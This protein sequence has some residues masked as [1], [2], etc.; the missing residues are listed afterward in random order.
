MILDVMIKQKGQGSTIENGECTIFDM[1]SWCQKGAMLS[2]ELGV[3]TS[4]EFQAQPHVFT[5]SP[6]DP[7]EITEKY[8]QRNNISAPEERI[9][10]VSTLQQ[11]SMPV[12]PA[13]A[14]QFEGS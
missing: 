3:E 7:E 14:A 13:L 6:D 12:D 1:K 2:K 8:L 5:F 11:K 10:S 9:E 4:V